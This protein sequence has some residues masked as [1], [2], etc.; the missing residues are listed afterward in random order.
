MDLDTSDRSIASSDM[1]SQ[2]QTDIELIQNLRA[3]KVSALGILYD[4]YVSLV[5]RLALRILANS[6]EAEDLTQEVFLALWQGGSYNS[7]R[8]SLGNFLNT[9]TRSRAIDRLRSRN[10]NANLLQRWEQ[11]MKIESSPLTPFELASLSQRSEYVSQAL[12]R[13]PPE[14]QQVLAMAYY[15]GLSQSAIAT[16]L[17][18]PLGTIKTRSRQGLLNLRKH[19]KD[20]LE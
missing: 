17:N 13:L 2:T 3:G 11:K 6:Q 5:H 7:T 18:T 16:Q 14:Q 15:D 19:L 1:P 9:M 8:G 4:R 12:A 10:T 20:L